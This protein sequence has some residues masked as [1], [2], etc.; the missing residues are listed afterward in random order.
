MEFRIAIKLDVHALRELGKHFGILLLLL[1]RY[2]MPLH[3]AV[4]FLS[5][6][7]RFLQTFHCIEGLELLSP[8]FSHHHIRPD[9]LQS[10][11]CALSE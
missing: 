4:P 6:P 5:V 7:Q 2:F 11:R 9:D 10:S 1:F 3:A 8:L